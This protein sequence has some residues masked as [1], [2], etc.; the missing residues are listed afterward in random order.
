MATETAG[1]TIRWDAELPDLRAKLVRRA[2]R[3]GVDAETAEDLAQEALYEAWRLRDRLYDP[4][5]LDRWLSAIL[6]NVH[7]R[8]LRRQG[9]DRAQLD[10]GT[11]DTDVVDVPA[12]D[13]F[14][15][16]V[17]LER[18]DLVDLLDR[19]LGLLPPETRDV[20]VH[21]FVAESPVGEVATRLGLT[22]GAVHMRLQRGKLALRQALTTQYSAEARS[23]GLIGEAE[24]GWQQTRIWCP[25]CG[26]ARMRG[27]FTGPNRRFEL[28]CCMNVIDS[29]TT[30]FGVKGFRATLLK[31]EAR[32]HEFWR[33]GI[34]GLDAH[35]HRMT[36]RRS[37]NDSGTDHLDAD[38][39][40]CEWNIT[41]SLDGLA[42]LG[43]EGQRFWHDH[44][45]IRKVGYQPIEVDGVPAVRTTFAAVNSAARLE[46]VLT[47]DAF[48]VIR[49][50][51]S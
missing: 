46:M 11:I 12:D 10:H 18:R 31:S 42:I 34:R 15:I 26:A 17:E 4:A 16:E 51:R 3:L 8:W 27:R 43:Q 30:S 47:K 5:G 41:T 25:F 29:E 21:R 44:S 45:R 28:Q 49:S 1:T 20:L 50:H 22:E 39:Y 7:L 33:E 38:C 37:I 48:Q 40:R 32:A 13:Q 23:L 9:R 35:E 14:D 24:I 36:L 6:G 19:A 2:R